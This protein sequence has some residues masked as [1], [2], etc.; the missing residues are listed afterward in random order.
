MCR[1]SHWFWERHRTTLSQAWDRFQHG[2]IFLSCIP[3]S[4]MALILICSNSGCVAIMTGLTK[5]H[6]PVAHKDCRVATIPTLPHQC[7]SVFCR[8]SASSVWLRCTL[9]TEP[10]LP[11]GPFA[12]ILIGT[13]DRSAK[14]RPFARSAKIESIVASAFLQQPFLCYGIRT[15]LRGYFRVSVSVVVDILTR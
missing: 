2:T 6:R 10:I 12:F 7:S 14:I 11:M 13:L 3:T 8:R 5:V 4:I 9:R 1:L 15:A